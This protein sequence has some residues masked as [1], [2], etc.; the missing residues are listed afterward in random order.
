MTRRY[1]KALY[2]NWHNI[3][4]ILYIKIS[5]WRTRKAK[6]GKHARWKRPLKHSRYI[7]YYSNKRLVVVVR[8]SG[9]KITSANFPV[10][11]VCGLIS[12]F[13]TWKQKQLRYTR[14]INC[15]RNDIM[16]YNNIV[17]IVITNYSKHVGREKP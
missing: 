8:W 11:S 17:S 7:L 12:R 14:Y 1:L 4:S 5:L 2:T 6:K 3:G 9:G 15:P 10:Y 16:I 13:V